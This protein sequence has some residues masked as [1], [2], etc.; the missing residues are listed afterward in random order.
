VRRSNGDSGATVVWTKDSVETNLR[1]AN[2]TKKMKSQISR[3][4][5][6]Q[7]GE[8]FGIMLAATALIVGVPLFT[9]TFFM[10]PSVDEQSKPLTSPLFLLFVPFIFAIMYSIFGYLTVWIGSAVYNLLFKY[11]GGFEF[12][13]KD[14]EA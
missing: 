14:K 5:P 11:I 12:E 7:N 13:Q 8:V 1:G 2:N 3:L 9:S 4:S 10:G 6:H